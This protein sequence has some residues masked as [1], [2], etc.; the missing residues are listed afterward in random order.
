MQKM[1]KCNK[2]LFKFNVTFPFKNTCVKVNF[3]VFYVL[4]LV[5]TFFVLQFIAHRCLTQ[6]SYIVDHPICHI[7]VNLNLINFKESI[8]LIY[9]FIKFQGPSGPQGPIGYP[10]PRGV[11]VNQEFYQKHAMMLTFGKKVCVLLPFQ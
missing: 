7:K 3:L 6:V 2:Y 10:G 1:Y 9:S 11:K 4:V 5:F 8:F